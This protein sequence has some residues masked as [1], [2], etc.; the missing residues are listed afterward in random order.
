MSVDNIIMAA[1][2]G[3]SS[4][5]AVSTNSD[6]YYDN[7]ALLISSNTVID[8]YFANVSLLLTGNDLLDKS[9]YKT[10]ITNSATAVTSNTTIKKFGT[11]SLD[12]TTTSRYLTVPN[13]NM[14]FGT[15]DLTVEFWLYYNSATAP[16]YGTFLDNGG[17]GVFF[18][19]GDTG[20][21][22]LFFNPSYASAAV[23]FVHNMVNNT[24]NHIAFVRYGTSGSIY[25]NGTSIGSVTLSSS[26][27]LNGSGS[28]AYIGAYSGSP[29]SSYTAAGYID[30]FRV[31]KG[32]ARYTTNFTPPTVSF[33]TH[34][35]VDSSVYR[36][37]VTTYGNARIDTANKKFGT[38][39]M[40]FDG[41]G[42][43]LLI[44]VASLGTADFTI[45]GWF[46]NS[47]QNTGIFQLL[48]SSS[49]PTGGAKPLALGV[50]TT[51]V[52]NLAYSG[53]DG[54]YSTG[55]FTPS[56]WNHFAVVRY[57]GV[58]NVYLNGQPVAGH[59]NLTDTFNYVNTYCWVGGMFNSGY[60]YN[61]YI[62]D[63]RITKG[64]ARYTANFP[65]PTT[66]LPT[67]PPTIAADPWWGNVSLLLDGT[68]VK[69]DPYWGNVGLL[70][71]GE[72]LADASDQNV[73]VTNNGAVVTTSKQK[74][75][76]SSIQVAY[77][78]GVTVPA[79]V[80][81]FG[82]TTDFTIEFWVYLNSRTSY[83][84]FCGQ[85]G[86]TV[87]FNIM[88]NTSSN[89]YMVG[90]QYIN[91][92][93]A[94]V[95]ASSGFDS[96]NLPLQQ[97]N[98]VAFSRSG[99]TC[100]CFINGV[101]A[102]LSSNPN[103][104][105]I[106]PV[107]V[108]NVSDQFSY[109]IDGYFADF[110]VTKNVARYISNFTVPDV[111][112]S[113]TK[114]A[115]RTQNNLTITPYGN[116]QLSTDV[117]KNGTGSMFFDGTGDYIAITP[118]TNLVLGTSDFTIEGW[119]Y[120]IAGG[121]Y[122]HIFTTTAS[123][124]TANQ[125]RMT[126]QSGT[127][128]SVFSGGSTTILTASTSYTQNT[129]NHF[130]LVRSGTT[131]TLY[132]NGVSVGSNTSVSTSFVADASWYVGSDSLYNYSWNGYIDDFRVTKGYARYTQNFT[133]PSQSFATQYLSTGYDPNYVDVT[134]LLNGNGTNGST[135]FTDLSSS[136]KTITN[137]GS[138]TTNTAIKKYGTGSIY[139]SG[140]NTLSAG[141]IVLGT[142]NFTIEFWFNQ[143]SQMPY[144][145]L[146]TTTASY[147]TANGLRV[148]TGGS[149]LTVFSASTALIQ[150]AITISNGSWYHFALVRN[151]TTL[152]LYQNGVSLGSTTTSISFV[153]DTFMVGGDTS[154]PYNGYIDDFRV[155]NG[156]ARYTQNF[157]PPTY[158]LSTDTTGTVIDPLIAS[159]SLLLRGNGTNGS[160]SFTDES[161]NN[162][163]ITNNGSVTV[164]T[165]TKKYGTGSM[166]FSGS[167]Y[168]KNSG[169]GYVTAYGTADFTFEFWF[170]WSNSISSA[171]LIFD[172]RPDGGTG[173]H[174]CV[175]I[176][177]ASILRFFSNG[178]TAIEGSGTISTNTWYHLAICRNNGITKMFLNGTQTGSSYSDS[179]NYTGVI[180]GPRIGGSSAISADS[181]VGYIDDFR[182]TKGYARYT[183]NFTP[184]TYEDP[185]ITGNPVDYNFAQVALLVNG[186]G[187]NGSTTFTDS[188]INKTA[189]NV[190]NSITCNT[191]IKKFGTGSMYYSGAGNYLSTV[192]SAALFNY[193]TS[194]LTIEG[195]Y[196][197]L[198]TTGN[199]L[200]TYFSAGAY[201]DGI[202]LREQ[203]GLYMGGS[204]V[205]NAA[206]ESNY[207][208]NKWFH[209]AFV[210][211]GNNISVYINGISKLSITRSTAINPGSALI[212]I[213][214]AVHN[215]G[216]EGWYGYIDDFRVTKGLARYTANFTPQ[217][218]EN[219]VTPVI[220]LADYYYANTTLLLT[221][222]SVDGSNTFTDLS[223]SHQTITNIGN[224]QANTSVVKYGLGSI[225]FNGSSGIRT[226][227]LTSTTLIDTS[228][229]FTVEG[230]INM[231]ATGEQE[232]IVINGNGSGS[233]GICLV[234]YG[235]SLK[236]WYN[237]YTAQAG[238]TAT[239]LGT[240]YHF[241]IVKF[242]TNISFYVNGTLVSSTNNPTFTAGTA[243]YV[244]IGSVTSGATWDANRYFTGYLDDVRITKGIARY[245]GTFTPPTAPLPIS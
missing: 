192:T 72:T 144:S 14:Q 211:F 39:A 60:V 44:P 7:V 199:G 106:G 109:G 201:T 180:N 236:F 189:I 240:W 136:P 219:S 215:A 128:L 221:G 209:L 149:N 187:T 80:F 170:N 171:N 100:K 86:S 94:D 91:T 184:P 121:T 5:A 203:D 140:T 37:P 243:N 137:N 195:W 20:S 31:T 235:T 67:I 130:A 3:S 40:Y 102:T 101:G 227:N 173:N 59:T 181:F 46:N 30:D 70:L 33:P 84:T 93:G 66:S 35:I 228:S 71:T 185:I 78:T 205:G 245:T 110:R 18:S 11:G 105:P 191:S 104:A 28:T 129:W 26:A 139:F 217:P 193:G 4:T 111:A 196:Y 216:S 222:D 41:S 132:L 29:G 82:T 50:Y 208:T 38:G 64:V 34:Q 146:F 53:S 229:S 176:T 79:S 65:V 97:W 231:L 90:I 198:G 154:Y 213:G 49:L 148:T 107:G 194:D 239:S 123:Y 115:D 162:L 24:W 226:A 225:Y 9:N 16:T 76:T 241:A 214:A 75:G 167:N 164:N 113:S 96:S 19:Y 168:L 172:C 178:A 47:A 244:E 204:N 114:I 151:G 22:L 45:E 58:L 88:L 108:G 85:W 52:F 218:Y 134:L 83:S 169:L 68:S 8:Q 17:Q 63:F 197:K 224:P 157:T 131:I 206:F 200:N 166:A 138:V 43:Y 119:F 190:T 234:A 120:Q 143:T 89:A 112:F 135:T 124:L 237:G 163:T 32:L 77:S 183:A 233:A 147:G 127:T 92:G 238:S 73:P 242:G 160:T 42:D 62:D 125:L 27:N 223:S 56:I 23:G 6:Q 122:A 1:G 165:T 202:L 179:N 12:F 55:S 15:G 126:N 95:F 156:I 158:Q 141:S 159:T 212:Y 133:P 103:I 21:K 207:S 230:W 174:F 51:N 81:N 118:T 153:S 116:V 57:N 177:S 117:K 175:Y 87:R 2:S 188:S 210:R 99:S 13:T 61:G 161:P 36:L 10:T 152:T 186:N 48:N 25:V 54:I 74:Y 150:P 142:N 69:N 220:T 145:H 155:T 232:V 182:I 98:H